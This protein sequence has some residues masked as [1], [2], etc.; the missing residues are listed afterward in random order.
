MN[1]KFY[2]SA[3]SPCARSVSDANSV[4]AFLNEID[5][6]RTEVV[7]DA[8][9][10]VFFTCGVI[11]SREDAYIESILT[12]AEQVRDGTEIVIAGCLP[13]INTSAFENYSHI[14]FL[15]SKQI[16]KLPDLL[17]IEEPFAPEKY[18]SQSF[19]LPDIINNKNSILS[20]ILSH[21]YRRNRTFIHSF[22]A[23]YVSNKMRLMRFKMR[24]KL[25]AF[26][27][28]LFNH[29]IHIVFNSS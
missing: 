27:L 21:P 17:N 22:P 7:D 12:Y 25:N 28:K 8:E 1:M 11:Q 3:V 13:D 5:W 14:H 9:V 19:T 2:A 4:V 24:T 20:K 23:K 29:E 26:E 16:E 18:S 6:E 15:S 10:C